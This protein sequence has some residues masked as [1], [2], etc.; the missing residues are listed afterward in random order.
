[1]T[2]WTTLRNLK[3]TAIDD[4]GGIARLL[5][6]IQHTVPKIPGCTKVSSLRLDM[7][8]DLPDMHRLKVIGHDFEL[9]QQ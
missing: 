9:R 5:D 4:G 8:A 2:P 3:L 7:L 1:M 6:F